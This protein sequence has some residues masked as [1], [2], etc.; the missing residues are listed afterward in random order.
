[1]RRIDFLGYSVAGLLM[2]VIAGQ[3]VAGAQDAPA[4]AGDESPVAKTAQLS[5][6]DQVAASKQYISR[7]ETMRDAIRRDLEEAR[8]QR[9]VVKT[10]C[11]NDKLN[12]IDVAL[13]SGSERGHALDL[14]AQRN[15]ADLANHEFT[16][17][18]VL[19]QRAQ[20][21]DAE[22]KQCIGK[23]IGFVGESSTTM[24][25]DPN[26]APEAASDYPESVVI[27]QPPQSASLYR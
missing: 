27:F 4:D 24:D 15:D 17:L 1:M 25:V 26:I 21:L 2:A 8:Q 23:E 19:F 7:M 20:Q 5:M 11:L 13:R 18:S 3:G 10:L 16:I 6:P 12:Q 22:A 14:A 9:D